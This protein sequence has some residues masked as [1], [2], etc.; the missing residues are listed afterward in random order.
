MARRGSK[1]ITTA[2]REK[3]EGKIIDF[4]DCR[5]LVGGYNKNGPWRK[6]TD[7]DGAKDSICVTDEVS[8]YF[9]DLLPWKPRSDGTYYTKFTNQI[10]CC[11]RAGFDC[12]VEPSAGVIGFSVGDLRRMYPKG[13][14]EWILSGYEGLKNGKDNEAIWL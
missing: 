4:F 10:T 5:V 14:P 3:I 7:W 13:I 8:D 2:R 6:M 11:I 12:A 1:N 9:S